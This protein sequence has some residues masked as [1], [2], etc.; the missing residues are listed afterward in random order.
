[1]APYRI[2]YKRHDDHLATPRGAR[3]MKR[4]VK[5]LFAGLL[6]IAAIVGRSRAEPINFGA[7]GDSLTD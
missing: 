5:K 7:V 1:M 6:L 3:L 2:S 4:C